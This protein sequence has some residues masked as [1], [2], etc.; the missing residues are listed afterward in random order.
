[1]WEITS[2]ISALGSRHR[3]AGLLLAVVVAACISFVCICISARGEAKRHLWDVTLTL[4]DG[5]EERDTLD[6]RR[7]GQE[8]ADDIGRLLDR[9]P[10][11]P[12]G[13]PKQAGVIRISRTDKAHPGWLEDIR[14]KKEA[15]VH[16]RVDL[17]MSETWTIKAELSYDRYGN[18]C[19][20]LRGERDTV[21]N[22]TASGP[23]PDLC[24]GVV[25]VGLAGYLR[26]AHRQQSVA[27]P[28]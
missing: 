8:L 27:L 4:A 28:E 18:L 19:Q 10:A 14:R 16:G 25:A 11:G 21:L 5:S 15:Q 13:A 9:F 2:K 6:G 1:M 7:S 3:R 26:E 12:T 20:L 22:P 17:N 24:K 23:N